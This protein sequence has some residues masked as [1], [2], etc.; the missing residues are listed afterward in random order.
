MLWNNTRGQVSHFIL[1]D[2]EYT[3]D[4]RTTGHK[5]SGQ[6]YLMYK[7]YTANV[8]STHLALHVGDSACLVIRC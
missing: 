7:H 8:L 5:T 6:T 2:L 1:V 4:Q 3:L